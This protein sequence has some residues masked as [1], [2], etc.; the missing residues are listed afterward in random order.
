MT[1]CAI[2]HLVCKIHFEKISKYLEQSWWSRTFLD[3]ELNLGMFAHI[4]LN[5]AFQQV[6]MYDYYNWTPSYHPV[7]IP[8][9]I[10][11]QPARS[12]FADYSNAYLKIK[13][14]IR[15]RWGGEERGNRE[16]IIRNTRKTD[17]LGAMISLVWAIEG[18]RR[19][20]RAA[21]RLSRFRV[22]ICLLSPLWMDLSPPSQD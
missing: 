10:T 22:L 21:A 12:W 2:L 17:L 15:Q 4:L 8:S 20:P 13:C 11:T 3:Y 5:S 19:R 9:A 16:R 6:C 14:R 1:W 18:R 7:A